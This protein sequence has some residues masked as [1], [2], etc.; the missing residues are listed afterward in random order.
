MALNGSRTYIRSSLAHTTFKQGI[1]NQMHKE[2]ITGANGKNLIY[3][4]VFVFDRALYRAGNQF[5]PIMSRFNRVH[6][7][8]S[9]F[10]QLHRMPFIYDI[11][12]FAASEQECK[13]N[14]RK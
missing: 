1:A 11:H 3:R 6:K 7:E 12:T 13:P 10:V 2:W 4:G 14:L 8:A 5:P 9:P